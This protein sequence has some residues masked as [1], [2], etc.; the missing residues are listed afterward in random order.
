MSGGSTPAHLRSRTLE[1]CMLRS[2]VISISGAIALPAVELGV[3]GTGS[4]LMNE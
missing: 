2:A 3:V 1:S 4:R